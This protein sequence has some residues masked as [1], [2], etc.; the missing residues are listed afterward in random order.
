MT[1][2]AITLL[3]TIA[4]VGCSKSSPVIVLDSWWNIDYAKQWCNGRSPCF[5]DPVQ[6]VRDFETELATQFAAQAAC[7]SVRFV[8][9]NGPEKADKAAVDA[10][11]KDHWNLSINFT[12]DQSKQQWQMLGSTNSAALMQGSGAPGEI[13]KNVCAI[14]NGH[15]AAIAN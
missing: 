10:I 5:P 12:P 15:G 13:A 3:L 7:K 9:F 8:R 6:G 1:K 2:R 14:V 11:A 4:I